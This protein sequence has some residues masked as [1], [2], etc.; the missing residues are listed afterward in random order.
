MTLVSTP[1][2]GSIGE[3][4]AGQRATLPWRRLGYVALGAACI[5]FGVSIT[6]SK[7]S[8][9][10]LHPAH[11][12]LW[13]F[14][15]ACLG[16]LP[17]LLARR[18]TISRADLPLAASIG[19][20]TIPVAYNLQFVGMTLTTATS[21]ALIIGLTP[22]VF[23]IVA[24]LVTRERLSAMTALAVFCAVGGTGL[25]IGQSWTADRGVGGGLVALSLIALAVSALLT[26]QLMQRYDPVVVTGYSFL[27]GTLALIP[28]VIFWAGP[29]P[30]QLAGDVWASLLFQGLVCTA[31]ANLFW[32]FGLSRVQAAHAGVYA[33]IEPIT[34][35][36]LGAIVFR[37]A[38]GPLTFVGGVLIIAGAVLVAIQP[39]ARAGSLQ[40]APTSPEAD[41]AREG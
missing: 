34:G 40:P 37:E 11:V 23:V 36:A 9:P 14:V 31:L 3:G 13:R 25:T 35:A 21:A 17:V 8:F 7:L 28:V 32:N 4:M 29:P 41:P 16:L 38:F 26:Q 22:V 1:D 30:V 18:S 15:F 5:L 6:L 39:A 2:N 33:N 20:L 19:V 10:F 24:M 12:V 27:L